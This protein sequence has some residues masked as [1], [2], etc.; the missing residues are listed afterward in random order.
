[1]ISSD[2]SYLRAW[3]L[4][5]GTR[6]ALRKGWQ[7]G[8]KRGQKYMA[9][10]AW[11]GL[12][13]WFLFSFFAFFLSSVGVYYTVQVEGTWRDITVRQSHCWIAMYKISSKCTFLSIKFYTM[14]H[15][16]T[17]RAF[18]FPQIC[19]MLDHIQRRYSAWFACASCANYAMPYVIYPRPPFAACSHTSFNQ[20][21]NNTLQQR[22]A[23]NISDTLTTQ[24]KRLQRWMRKATTFLK[25][26]PPKLE[27]LQLA[28]Q[29]IQRCT[30][31]D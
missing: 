3:W 30:W 13:D 14:K 10:I 19:S 28:A 18:V 6:A 16:K 12:M 2:Q 31:H 24:S 21:P 5:L 9:S 25:S 17:H 20:H 15:R 27:Y 11:S 8:W 23:R 4:N 1:M 7:A 22:N 29:W 26:V